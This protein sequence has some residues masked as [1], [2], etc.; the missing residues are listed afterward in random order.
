MDNIN[1]SSIF[2][3]DFSKILSKERL[4]YLIRRENND[5]QKIVV[6][7]FNILRKILNFISIQ[8]GCY[9]SRMTGSGSVCFG[10][11]R[12]KKLAILGLKRIKKKFPKY[13]CVLS[14]TI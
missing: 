1:P 4:L 10:I 9:F 11:F 6:S 2:K 12:S 13:W 7:N 8:N 3:V 14:K 5:L